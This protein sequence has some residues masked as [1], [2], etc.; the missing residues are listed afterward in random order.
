[1]NARAF[2]GTPK[3]V[4]AMNDMARESLDT[5]SSAFS[6]WMHNANRLQAESIRFMNDRFTKDLQNL[7]RISTCR[8]PEEFVSVQSELYTQ[9]VSDYMEQGARLMSLFGDIGRA[10][11]GTGAKKQ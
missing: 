6:T 3:G 7:T 4:E 8:S 11:P 2:A 9:L 10:A 1:M 5:V